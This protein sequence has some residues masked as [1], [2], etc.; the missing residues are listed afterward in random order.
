MN[1]QPISCPFKGDLE[2]SYFS[3]SNSKCSYPRSL[4][5]SC[6]DDS[7]LRF[8]FRSCADVPHSESKGTCLCILSSICTFLHFS[9]V[10]FVSKFIPFEWFFSGHHALIIINRCPVH[11]HSCK[12]SALYG[13]S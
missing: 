1:V 5:Q 10:F 6:T 8:R 2:F 3:S 7:R 9:Q 4:V 11:S 12:S 13:L